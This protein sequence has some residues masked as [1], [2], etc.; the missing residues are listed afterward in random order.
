MAKIQIRKG[1]FE[2]NSS[3][4]HSLVMCD[5]SDF[6][7]WKRGELVFSKDTETLVPID[8]PYYVA[9]S[10]MSLKEKEEHWSEHDYLTYDQFFNDWGALEY[11]TFCSTYKTPEGN[12][13][14]AFGYYGYN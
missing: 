9:W 2:T 8:N 5:G 6:E 1:L 13:V 4:V 3:S 7:K 10:K 14:V 11:E 12:E